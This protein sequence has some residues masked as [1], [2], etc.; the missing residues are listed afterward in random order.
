MFF[1]EG[2]VALSD[3]TAEVFRRLQEMK[4]AGKTGEG[5]LSELL[6]ISVWDICDASTKVGVTGPDG[7]VI[8]ASKALVAWADPRVLSNEHLNL[9][10]GTV[11][12]T[13]LKD[14]T[15]EVPSR[16]A[17]ALRYGAFVNMPVVIPINNFQSSM[18]FLAEEVGDQSKKDPEVV[19]AART[20]LQALDGGQL[21]T[22]ETMRAKLGSGLS[23]RKL[24]LAWGL[25][26][27][28]RPALAEPNRWQGL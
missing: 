20:I 6:A 12:S 4:A 11:G 16:E 17:L 24:K 10:A 9:I 1:E 23:R 19:D 5:G 14:E 21:V 26:A 2:W 25:A 27:Q 7:T 22:R 28:H 18:T 8:A 3:V 15:G 13:T